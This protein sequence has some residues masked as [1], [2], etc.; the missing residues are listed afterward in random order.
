MWG[1]SLLNYQVVPLISTVL[2]GSPAR[3]AGSAAP[4]VKK[5]S[6]CVFVVA[7]HIISYNINIAHYPVTFPS[8]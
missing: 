7:Y 5:A 1:L 4:L 2:A 8:L 6:K 3:I